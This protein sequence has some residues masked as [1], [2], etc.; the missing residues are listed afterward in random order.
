[1]L[2]P[3]L[4]KSVTI[5]HQIT[6]LLYLL[7]LQYC[8]IFLPVILKFDIKNMKTKNSVFE[9]YRTHAKTLACSKIDKSGDSILSDEIRKL[10]FDTGASLLL[11]GSITELKTIQFNELPL[12]GA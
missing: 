3:S 4:E 9:T 10:F 8:S 2:E 6:L 5:S 12:L 7:S 11:Y 1:M